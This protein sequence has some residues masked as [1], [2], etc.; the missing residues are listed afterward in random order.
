MALDDRYVKLQIGLSETKRSKYVIALR[1]TADYYGWTE[2]FPRWRPQDAVTSGG[3]TYF[4]DPGRRGSLKL[5]GG[6]RHRICRSPSTAGQPAGKTNAFRLST[7]CTQ[8]D[9]AE[10]AHF[11][12]GEWYWLEGLNGE[13]ITRER[14]EA[15]YQSDTSRAEGGLVPA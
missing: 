6:N 10:L 11:T 7:S 1:T 3:R 12:H 14:W 5:A 15:I 2:E 8:L 4:A 9:I 13:R